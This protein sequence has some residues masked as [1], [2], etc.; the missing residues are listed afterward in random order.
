MV[1][2][3]FNKM[4]P[5]IMLNLT[6]L[7]GAIFFGGIVAYETSYE[8]F[9]KDHDRV[10]RLNEV[11]Y[12]NAP[13]S[14]KVALSMYPMGPALVH[15]F[16]DV[17]NYTRLQQT[18]DDFVR[19]QE[20]GLHSDIIFADSRFF[21]VLGF[22][23]IEGI[24]DSALDKPEQV[25]LTESLARK[26]F[27]SPKEAIGKKVIIAGREFEVTAVTIDA[28]PNSHLEFDLLMSRITIR[29]TT[30]VID[31][32]VNK[33][34]TYIKFREGS[35]PWFVADKFDEFMEANLENPSLYKLYMQP[36]DEIHYG[37]TSLLHDPFNKDKIGPL[38]IQFLWYS[39]IAF[40]VVVVLVN[41]VA[42]RKRVLDVPLTGFLGQFGKYLVSF[43]AVLVVAYGLSLLLFFA[44]NDDVFSWMLQSPKLPLMVLL[45]TGAHLAL[46]AFMLAMI[47][48]FKVSSS[49]E[50]TG[51]FLRPVFEKGMIV[52]IFVLVVSL[53]SIGVFSFYLT[54]TKVQYSY[55]RILGGESDNVVLV[56]LKATT[57]VHYDT[58][59]K[60]L[61]GSE[62]VIDVT[63]FIEFPF[64]GIHQ[65]QLV[66]EGNSD[67][68]RVTASV[69]HVNT[70]FF[71]FFEIPLLN[72]RQFNPTMFNESEIS[73]MINRSLA[74]MLEWDID[75][76]LGNT[77]GL[78]SNDVGNLIG[79]VEDFNFLPGYFESGP[80]LVRFSEDPYGM[81][82][83][84]RP[85][86]KEEALAEF[87]AIWD[88]WIREPIRYYDYAQFVDEVYNPELHVRYVAQLTLFFV[89]LLFVV[90]ALVYREEISAI[91]QKGIPGNL[92]RI[93]AILVISGL[94][95]LL[96]FNNN[97][98][99]LF[100]LK[101]LSM[102]DV[103]I[104]VAITGTAV[105]LT[106][107]ASKRLR[108]R[109]V[110]GANAV[111]LLFILV[112]MSTSCE[113]KEAPVQEKSLTNYDLQESVDLGRALFFDP[114][115][116][117]NNTTSCASCHKKE[118]AFADNQ[119]FSEGFDKVLTSRNTPTVTYMAGRNVFFWDG[120]AKNLEIQSTMPIADPHEM[121][122]TM[123]VVEERLQ[124]DAQYKELF[125]KAFN[126]SPDSASLSV[127]LADYQKTLDF[128]QSKYDLYRLSGDS[129]QMSASALRGMR[130]FFGKAECIICHKGADFTDDV[131]RNIGINDND[132]GRF[133]ITQDSSDM[134]KFKTP[135]LRNIALT[136]PYMHNGSI[137][138]LREVIEFYNEPMAHD[139]LISETLDTLMYEPLKLTNDEIVDV[140]EFLLTLTDQN[141]IQ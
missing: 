25:V 80:M 83:K 136:A 139:V 5:A 29:E 37:S 34:I 119:T 72:G 12:F 95:M 31:W 66:F 17:I 35:N 50:Q 1:T 138:T 126:R 67:G 103:A 110:V 51:L 74:E 62:N 73:F 2:R 106:F 30:D 82:L 112:L 97:T 124:N 65:Q 100:A 19:Y 9:N 70:G 18:V 111:I 57:G 131:F 102:V 96:L 127:A 85:G 141:F 94:V 123:E 79:V 24:V 48:Y 45:A 14:Q 61:N 38:S 120:R 36:I 89:V 44:I 60:K 20:K 64:V 92:L 10:F 32:T 114:M 76:S 116:S 7:T 4:L 115:L 113:S 77:I 130:L 15:S 56:P 140:E 86:K 41:W 93:L 121:G 16:T 69:M 128:R 11:Q 118:F 22:P 125:K 129:S 78:A 46:M 133:L 109:L 99:R 13:D 122:L 104:F 28:P 54:Y 63:S 23:V 105:F 26:F 40:L 33:F 52:T 68:R 134:R 81:A 98:N 137:T 135:H 43:L 49:D 101:N 53:F 3:K 27:A 8:D 58:F 84:Y 59:L 132:L 42:L 108:Q 39:L 91:H 21:D 87:E 107:F 6:L 90:T 88:E 55:K 117:N 75:K 47:A 71:E